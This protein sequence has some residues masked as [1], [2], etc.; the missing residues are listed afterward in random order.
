MWQVHSAGKF[1]KWIV[2]YPQLHH[3][4]PGPHFRNKC[5]IQQGG[6]AAPCLTSKHEE[7]VAEVSDLRTAFDFVLSSTRERLAFCVGK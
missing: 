7:P 1:T 3:L 4:S 6:L 2:V 5:R